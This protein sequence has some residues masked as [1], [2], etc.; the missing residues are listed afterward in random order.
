VGH[1][2]ALRHRVLAAFGKAIKGARA[3]AGVLQEE[4]AHLAGIDRS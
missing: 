3:E 1:R 2:P 4:L